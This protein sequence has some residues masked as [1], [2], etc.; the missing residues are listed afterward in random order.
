VLQL[1][2]QC[3]TDFFFL[4]IYV[5]VCFESITYYHYSCFCKNCLWFLSFCW[6]HL[7][8]EKETYLLF[9][10][11]HWRKAWIYQRG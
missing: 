5:S 9:S 7:I 3:H 2:C 11:E 10:N 1:N 4:F 8:K 6:T